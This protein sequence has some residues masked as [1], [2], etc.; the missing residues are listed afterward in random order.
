MVQALILLIVWGRNHCNKFSITFHSLVYSPCFRDLIKNANLK[1]KI[2]KYEKRN[3]EVPKAVYV[4]STAKI[5]L[6]RNVGAEFKEALSV[7]FPSYKTSQI[8][9]ATHLITKGEM[10]SFDILRGVLKGCII[11][12][13]NSNK[14]SVCLHT[15]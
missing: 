9:F 8:K 12:D 11:Y 4:A 7:Y 13:K 15:F 2:E 5:Y 3:S 6:C 14:Y 1:Q 10:L